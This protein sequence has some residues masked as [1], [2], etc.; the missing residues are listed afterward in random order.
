MRNITRNPAECPDECD[1]MEYITD[2]TTTKVS[3][4]F[5]R[6]YVGGMADLTKNSYVLFTVYY[7]SFDVTTIS[8][9]GK[10]RTRFS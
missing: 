4:T 5:L 2:V 9:H 1:Y 6:E 8:Y 7:R 10:V 3:E